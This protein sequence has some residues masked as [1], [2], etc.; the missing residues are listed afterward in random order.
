MAQVWLSPAVIA[1][2]V[3]PVPRLMVFPG[4]LVLSVPPF[5]S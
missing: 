4:V 5:A 2:A 3:R 1:V